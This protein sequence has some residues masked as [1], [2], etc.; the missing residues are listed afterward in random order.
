MT[1]I[2]SAQTLSPEKKQLLRELREIILTH[3]PD[4]RILLYGSVARGTDDAESDI[5]ILIIMAHPLSWQEEEKVR[6]AIYD[7]ELPRFLLV[8]TIFVA[9]E[10]WESPGGMNS[11][12]YCNVQE[13]AI[14]L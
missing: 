9:R 6:S 2:D 10:E 1:A 11:P 14:Q 3:L 12:F 8:S 5:D 7:F 13:D 4:C